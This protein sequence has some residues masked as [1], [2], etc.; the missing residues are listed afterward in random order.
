MIYKAIIIGSYATALIFAVKIITLLRTYMH[1]IDIRSWLLEHDAI[2]RVKCYMYNILYIHLHVTIRFVYCVD[3]LFYK[4]NYRI[5]SLIFLDYLI[6]SPPF[7][8]QNSCNIFG[9]GKILKING[10]FHTVFFIF[11]QPSL[12]VSSSFRLGCFCAN[13]KKELESCT[14]FPLP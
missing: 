8:K 9:V 3:L 6:F 4:N 1:C 5:R 14:N 7:K 12:Q 13:L 11:E 2:I 10:L